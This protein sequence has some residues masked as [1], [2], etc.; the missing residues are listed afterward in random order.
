V[1][2]SVE[3][4]PANGSVLEHGSPLKLEQGQMEIGFP[5]G[6][7][8]NMAKDADFVAEIRTLAQ[9]FTGHETVVR[10]K[11]ITPETG[12]PPQSL[13]EKKKSDNERLME[14]L[15]REVAEHPVINEAVRVFGGTVTEI[16]KA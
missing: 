16:C 9:E 12:E 11:E 2:F 8:L 10:I 4:R 14:D 15:R 7:Y 1:A 3:K 5:A 6:H 13:A